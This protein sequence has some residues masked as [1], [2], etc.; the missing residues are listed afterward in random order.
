M[1]IT[2]EIV[3]DLWPLVASGE[4]SSDTRSM[5]EGFL[6]TDPEFAR[7]LKSSGDLPPTEVVMPPDEEARAL[8]RTRDL[9]HGRSWLRGL[10]LVALALTGLTVARVVENTTWNDATRVCVANAI[11]AGVAWILYL[12]LLRWQR[13]RALRMSPGRSLAR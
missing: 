2:R 8:A 4:A 7:R 12:S 13:V 6:Q 11:V 10:R 3:S 1:K 5:V 9:V